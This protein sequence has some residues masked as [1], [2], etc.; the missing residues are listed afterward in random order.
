M[1][2][3]INGNICVASNARQRW[4]KR[5][6]FHAFYLF[7]LTCFASEQLE[8]TIVENV[9]HAFPG[10]DVT[11][12][13]GILKGD[14]IHVTQVQ[15]TKTDDKPPSR[16]GVYHPS[17]GTQY[18]LFSKTAYNYSV[19][20]NRPSHNCWFGFKETSSPQD[21]TA[22]N[23][24]CYQWTLHLNNVSLSLSGLY[25]CSFATYPL[26]IRSKEINLIIQQDDEKHYTEEVLLN[27]TLEIPC[28][29][30]MLSV[31]LS[32]APMKWLVKKN[33]D[34]EILIAKESYHHGT[35][36]INSALYK[37]RIKLEPDNSLKI[38]PIHIL[39]DGREFSC[40]IRYHP[41]RILKSI[42]K[43][44][45]FAKP[46]I[47][48]ISHS[49]STSAPREANITCIV[50]K[51]FP[52]PN[53][54]W[55]VDGKTLEDKS[56][57][58]LVENEETKDEEGFYELRSVLI[59]QNI[60]QFFS[61]QSFWC[62][63]VY[64]FP[65][66]ETQNISSE[67]I[68]LPFGHEEDEEISM[69]FTTTVTEG[70]QTTPSASLEFTNQVTSKWV[71]ATTRQ[72][73]SS[74]S[75]Q[76]YTN[77]TPSNEIITKHTSFSTRTNITSRESLRGNLS[78]AVVD[79]TSFTSPGDLSTIKNLVNATG[80]R[81]NPRNGSFA[82][83]AVVAA[84]LLF[85]TSLIILGIRKW[86]QYQKEILNRPPSFKPPPPPI[87]YTSMQE[88]DGTNQSCHEMENL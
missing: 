19:A 43:V 71:S 70:L 62:M 3:V 28:L 53:L 4:G 52:K 9:V 79:L 86:C 16:I 61:N 65:G 36:E 55:Y 27:Q 88:S 68:V 17:Y 11:L 37:G 2:L 67:A 24:E 74:V 46:D 47:S 10:S 81:R 33:G 58:M 75:I 41:E 35:P 31:N 85:C 49:E 1:K 59:I 69:T 30:D 5:C 23:M 6:S 44:K 60:N 51:A 48:I 20:F 13:C 7:I 26:G 80:P 18:I 56:E 83:P 87:K 84:M 25:E 77:V 64:P 12:T 54:T 22:K 73:E 15:W 76:D 39:D 32:R 40:Y 50:R 38:S 14:G 34:E 66:N 21:S 57:G 8:I 63:S 42:T 29:K 45:V 82:W 78:A 72:L